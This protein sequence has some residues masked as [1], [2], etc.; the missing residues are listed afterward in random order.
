VHKLLSG[1][2]TPLLAGVIPVFEVF[3]TGWEKLAR[4]RKNLAP[5]IQCG[6]DRA[7]EYYNRLDK[8]NAYVVAMGKYFIYNMQCTTP[9]RFMICQVINPSVRMSWITNNW[10]DH[11]ASKAARMMKDLVSEF[12]ISD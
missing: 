6:L 10:E 11:W 1:E 8:S 3:L 9:D 12:L 2:Q 5:F 7:N 4:K